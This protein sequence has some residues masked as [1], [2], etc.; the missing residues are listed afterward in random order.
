MVLNTH[1][2]ANLILGHMRYIYLAP[3]LSEENRVLENF[4]KL[5]YWKVGSNTVQAKKLFSQNEKYN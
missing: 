3:N 4:C 1:T 2:E 5:E